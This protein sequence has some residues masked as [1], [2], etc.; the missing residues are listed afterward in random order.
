M[1]YN[2][3]NLQV[4]P[5]KDDT[6][7]W[8]KVPGPQ[9]CIVK[10]IGLPPSPISN[11]SVHRRNPNNTE[12]HVY[13]NVTWSPPATSNGAVVQYDIRVGTLPL[14]L[15]SPLRESDIFLERFVRY[16]AIFF[17]YN[18]YIPVYLVYHN[19]TTEL[20]HALLFNTIE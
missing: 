20:T 4:R 15:N 14:M 17:N 13:F 2:N 12:D 1:I 10:A 18:N 19:F 6:Y 3:L 9:S 16:E 7:F 8:R 11:I 5:E